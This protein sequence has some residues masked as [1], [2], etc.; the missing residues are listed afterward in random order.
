MAVPLRE[1]QQQPSRKPRPKKPKAEAILIKPVWGRSFA[2][3]L[4]QIKTKAK[5]EQKEMVIYSIKHTW[6]EDVLLNLENLSKGSVRQSTKYCSW[7]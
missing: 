6:N 4:D 1:T 2:D 3:I 5:P 7:G